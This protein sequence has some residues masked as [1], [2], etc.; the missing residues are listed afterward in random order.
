MG[1]KPEE[2]KVPDWVKDLDLGRTV[3]NVLMGDCVVRWEVLCYAYA[4]LVQADQYTKQTF[5]PIT[6]YKDRLKLSYVRH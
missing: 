5:C 6:D 4:P 1:N 3:E 2:A